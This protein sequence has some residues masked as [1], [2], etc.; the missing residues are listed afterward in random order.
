MDA[1]GIL[2]RPCQPDF[3][4]GSEVR[5]VGPSGSIDPTFLSPP[6]S[7]ESSPLPRHRL[8][9][10]ETRHDDPDNRPQ[11]FAIASD[12]SRWISRTSD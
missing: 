2:D 1:A 4:A 12:D 7:A 8:D 10:P 11:P 5:S 3:N 9:Q 6:D